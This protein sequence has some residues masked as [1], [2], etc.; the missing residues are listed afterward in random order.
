MKVPQ[1]QLLRAIR[2]AQRIPVMLVP[3]GA[4]NAWPE[5]LNAP[6]ACPVIRLLTPAVKPPFVGHVSYVLP[7]F[8]YG[9][10]AAALL[11]NDTAE[12]HD[13]TVYVPAAAD[14]AHADAAT[15]ART[16]QRGSFAFR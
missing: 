5:K 12:L 7:A 4:L 9:S 13:R 16:M 3:G 1:L 6:N 14:P 11:P 10:H 8:E 2:P 15:S